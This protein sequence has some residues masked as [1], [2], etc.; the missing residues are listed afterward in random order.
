MCEPEGRLAYRASAMM[1]ILERAY[2]IKSTPQIEGPDWLWEERYDIDATLP[3]GASREQVPAMLRGLLADRFKLAAHIVNREAPSF[4]LV[5][6]KAGSKLTPAKEGATYANKGDRIGMHF[7]QNMPLANLA[8]FL[9]NQLQ[10]P[11][12]D[13]TGLKGSFWIALDYVPEYPSDKSGGNGLD[14]AP[15]LRVAIEEQLGL[16]LEPRKAP[17]EFLAIDHI[18][19]APSEN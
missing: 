9:A 3:E 12:A 1:F 4:A 5:V 2:G 7:R 19:K 18:E 11:V 13:E 16:K 6:G 15:P 14:L 10:K 17:V 8:Q